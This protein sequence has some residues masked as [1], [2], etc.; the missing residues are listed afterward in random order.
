MCV[1]CSIGCAVCTSSSSCTLPINGFT[2]VGGSP[3]CDASLNLY[4]NGNTC[5]ICSDIFQGCTECTTTASVTTC[6]KC[7]DLYF[8]SSGSCSPC[9]PSCATCTNSTLCTSCIQG[10]T[11]APDYTCNCGAACLNCNTG[12][13]NCVSCDLNIFGAFSQCT[14]C[15][16]GFYLTNTSTCQSCPPSSNCLSCGAGGACLTCPSTF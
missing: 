10:Y 14:G 1:A 15:A 13:V 2:L 12:L 4:L 3:S 8:L 11:L 5:Q 6:S 7:S 16:T 9:S